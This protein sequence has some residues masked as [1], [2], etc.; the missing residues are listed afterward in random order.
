MAPIAMGMA[1]WLVPGKEQYLGTLLMRDMK[2]K[3]IV[4]PRPR[5]FDGPVAVLVDGLSASCSELFSGGLKDLGRARIIG[6]TTAGAVLMSTV[7]ELPNGDA[8]QFA[9]ADYVSRGGETLEGIGVEP[10]DI[11]RHTRKA[12]LA[13][14][15]LP[16]EQASAWILEQKMTNEITEVSSDVEKE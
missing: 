16:M 3:T 6:T 1:G 15:D 7:H 10:H 8:L 12:L 5:T 9:F 4:Y 2:L 13:G 11:V 14:R